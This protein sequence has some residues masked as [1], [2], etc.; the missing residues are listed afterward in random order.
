MDHFQLSPLLRL[1]GIISQG[2]DT[3]IRVLPYAHNKD[4][5]YNP[6]QNTQIPNFTD[7]LLTLHQR[8]RHFKENTLSA[9]SPGLGTPAEEQKYKD[10]NNSE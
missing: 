7:Q 10:D 3:N 9:H 2:K 5:R 1:R 8:F 6:F 4:G